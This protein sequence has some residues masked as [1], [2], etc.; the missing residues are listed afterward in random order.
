MGPGWQIKEPVNLEE[1]ALQF[2]LKALSLGCVFV[3]DRCPGED[4]HVQNEVHVLLFC[5]DHRVCE[6]RKH[7]YV[8]AC[9]WGLFSGPTLF[10][11]TGQRPTCSLFPF[12]SRP[13]LYFFF[14]FLSLWISLWLAETSQQVISQ[15][16][17]LKVTPHCNHSNHYLV[18]LNQW[19]GRIV[20][21]FLDLYVSNGF[22]VIWLFGQFRWS[23]CNR[24]HRP[25]VMCVDA[26]RYNGCT[27]EMLAY[28]TH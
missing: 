22:M 10:A 19:H 5:L 17:R 28:T 24:T 9:F 20:W 8:Y 23:S 4:E 2:A 18:M 11:A 25:C 16:T 1:K 7:F 3:C 13:P 6:L 21:F 27:A 14:F 26:R 12:L 15:T